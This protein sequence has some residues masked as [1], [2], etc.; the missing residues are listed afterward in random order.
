MWH[1]LPGRDTGEQHSH[2]THAADPLT[3]RGPFNLQAVLGL[4][5]LNLDVQFSPSGCTWPCHTQ[6]RCAGTP[7]CRPP[8]A[9]RGKAWLS[10]SMDQLGWALTQQM[11]CCVHT[12]HTGSH[13]CTLSVCMAMAWLRCCRNR[14]GLGTR[15]VLLC[16]H[17]KCKHSVMSTF[18]CRDGHGMAQQAQGQAGVWQG[19]SAAVPTLK[20]RHSLVSSAGRTTAWLSCCKDRLGLG[21]AEALLLPRPTWHHSPATAFEMQSSCLQPSLPTLCATNRQPA[22]SECPPA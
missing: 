7:Q 10:C 4:A 21:I 14:L 17:A 1:F 2:A 11:W 3:S 13:S 8:S 19:R 20:Y 16:P 5:V 6:T 12:R 9:G 15:E 18:I 22:S